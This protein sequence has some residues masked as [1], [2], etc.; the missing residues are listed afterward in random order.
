MQKP[1]LILG[2]ANF[3]PKPYGV[4]EKPLGLVDI[5]FILEFAKKH[6]IT[7]LEG[8]EL[9]GCDELLNDPTFDLI[10]K[11]KH[12][13]N[14]GR[15]LERTGRKTL[16]GLMYHHSETTKAQKLHPHPAVGYQGA[17]IYNFKQLLNTEDMVEVPLNLDDRTFEK[18]D[19]DCKIV[20][21]VFGRGELFKKYSVKECLDY[22]KGLS[23]VHGVVIGVDS[24]GQLEQ[25]LEA[26]NK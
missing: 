23:N 8:S 15:V 1:K 7:M 10:Y 4:L 12:P 17:S 26:W 20:R 13:Y 16:M 11:V 18:A 21:S 9:Y 5:R 14:L 25:V 3:G 6:G 24:V 19:Y 2:T 22:I